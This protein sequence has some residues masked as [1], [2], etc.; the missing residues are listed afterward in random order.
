MTRTKTGIKGFDELVGGG[1]VSGSTVLLSGGAGSGKTV[2]GLQ[3]LYNGA[4]RFDEPGVYVT[5]ET[6]PGDLRLEASQFG[7]DLAQ[8]EKNTQVAIVDA[9]SSTA[10]LPTS[11]KYTLRRGFD[12]S[13]LAEEI[14]R[15]VEDLKAKRLVVDCL[16][17]LAM[18]FDTSSDVRAEI[19]RISAFLQ[20]LKVTS[21]LISESLS[22]GNH[23][24]NGVEQ[25]V[26][27]GLVT[28]N[29]SEADGRLKRTLTV[30]KM[31][32]TEHSLRTHEFSITGSGIMLNPVKVSKRK[33]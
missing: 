26:T 12:V 19:F 30:W 29:L 22:P 16:S 28:L 10:G 21:L 11:E 33:A 14:Y 9:A 5:T 4:S 31:R 20:E 7:W 1:F 24:R 8:L 17:A 18:Q 25:F 15:A 3:F 13:S 27:Q 23:S 2:F 6:R 32:Q